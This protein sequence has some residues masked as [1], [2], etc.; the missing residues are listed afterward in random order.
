MYVHFILVCLLNIKKK[1]VSLQSA[2][3]ILQFSILIV[4]LFSYPLPPPFF[5]NPITLIIFS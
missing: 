5:H 3:K 2:S 1:N 4:V